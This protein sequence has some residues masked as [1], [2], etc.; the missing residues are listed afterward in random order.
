MATPKQ[1]QNWK[2]EGRSRG[3]VAAAGHAANHRPERASAVNGAQRAS[4]SDERHFGATVVLL[5]SIW[6]AGAPSRGDWSGVD[7]DGSIVFVQ[8][9]A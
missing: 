6:S 8:L 9:D 4:T 7:D 5:N 3:M 1:R 2:H